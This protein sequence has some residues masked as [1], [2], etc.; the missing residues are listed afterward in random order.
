MESLQNTNNVNKSFIIVIVFNGHLFTYAC[1]GV[2]HSKYDAHHLFGLGTSVKQAV[3]SLTV[4]VF[5]ILSLS[6]VYICAAIEFQ[7]SNTLPFK[8]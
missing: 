7:T 5:S 4:F 3:V 8:L 6:C 2:H 1:S